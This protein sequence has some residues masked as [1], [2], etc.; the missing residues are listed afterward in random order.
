MSSLSASTEAFAFASE[1]APTSGSAQEVTS[2][3]IKKRSFRSLVT[4]S[5]LESAIIGFFLRLP[6]V[7]IPQQNGCSPL[8]I[9]TAMTKAPKTPKAAKT[10][11]A[12]GS[13]KKIPTETT[14][15]TKMTRKTTRKTTRKKTRKKTPRKQQ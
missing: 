11:K 2:L 13:P 6:Q 5:S 4:E 7:L 10:L 3:P 14:A 9:L 1:A 15:T 12:P 8:S